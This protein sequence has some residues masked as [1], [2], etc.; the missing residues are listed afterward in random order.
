MCA[1]LRPPNRRVR[2]REMRQADDRAIVTI[3]GRA[4]P[5]RGNDV[6][7][8]RIIPA[9]YLKSVSFEGLEQHLFADERAHP[10]AD[11]KYTGAAIMFV[12]A[13][14]GC[15]SSREHAPQAIHRRGIRAIVGESFSEIFFGNAV[16]LGLPCVRAGESAIADA[17]TRIERDPAVEFTVDLGQSRVTGGGLDF[18]L[19]LAD[20][21]R[22]AFLTGAWDATGLL[23]E[24]PEEV[25]AVAA[26]LP[27][28]AGF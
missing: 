21:A 18:P 6:D 20:A 10:T 12:N 13:N 17:M 27:Y 14:F 16:A 24:R 22:V 23:R 7:T 19:Q 9:R 28:I 8:D 26:R 4:V 25:D 5:V 1:G 2:S 11:P 3:G 15:G